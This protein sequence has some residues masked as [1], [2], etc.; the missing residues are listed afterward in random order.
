ML[1]R[2]GLFDFVLVFARMFHDEGSGSLKSALNG[3]SRGFAPALCT[4]EEKSYFKWHG[5]IS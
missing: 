1:G 5:A 3:K 4:K 2:G